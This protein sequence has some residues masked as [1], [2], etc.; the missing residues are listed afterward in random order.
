MPVEFK[1][2]LTVM[3]PCP[4][5]KF[6]EFGMREYTPTGRIGEDTDAVF[7]ELG[8]SPEEIASLREN[9]EII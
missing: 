1:D 2:G 4:P 6:S 7:T 5:V 3:M 8:Y 9:K